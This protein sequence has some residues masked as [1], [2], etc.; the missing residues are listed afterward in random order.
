MKVK[1]IRWRDSRMY[2]TQTDSDTKYEPCI[3]KSIGFVIEETKSHITLAGDLVDDD[4]RRVIV[5]PKENI[6]KDKL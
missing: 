4:Y 6:I 1:T 3:I 5:I 2:I